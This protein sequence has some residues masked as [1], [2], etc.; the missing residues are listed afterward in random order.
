MK[1]GIIGLGLIGGS[2]AKALKNRT[3]NVVFGYDIMKPSFLQQTHDL[4]TVLLGQSRFVHGQHI[5]VGHLAQLLGKHFPGHTIED[6]KS[7]V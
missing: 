5:H 2:M 3:E 4:S 7:V 1:I 6:R